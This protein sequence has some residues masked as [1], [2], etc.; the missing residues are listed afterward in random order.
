VT[1]PTASSGG[2]RSE[3][4]LTTCGG[5][6]AIMALFFLIS[7]AACATVSVAPSLP[8]RPSFFPSIPCWL[9]CCCCACALEI[10][11]AAAFDSRRFADQIDRTG[12]TG[13]GRSQ[14]FRWGQFCCLLIDPAAGHSSAPWTGR[15]VEHGESH[16]GTAE[17]HGALLAAPARGGAP[18]RRQQCWQRWQQRGSGGSS[19]PC[20][21]T[22]EAFHAPPRPQQ[23]Q[24][25]PTAGAPSRIARL[26]L[27]QMMNGDGDCGSVSA[28]AADTHDT[29]AAASDGRGAAVA[30]ERWPELD[31]YLD[32]AVP[33]TSIGNAAAKQQQQL[34][35]RGRRG[36]AAAGDGEGGEQ[37]SPS[38]LYESCDARIA[39]ASALTSLE[40]TDTRLRCLPADGELLGG[41]EE[42]QTLR[43]SNNALCE[44]P[45]PIFSAGAGLPRLAVLDL[46]RNELQ[47]LPLSL[48]RLPVLQVLN[49][50][51]CAQSTRV[52]GLEAGSESEQ[53]E[54]TRVGRDCTQ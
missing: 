12:G 45:P 44:L 38:P 50:A 33:R 16:W 40:I 17:E 48:S 1:A 36:N 5:C 8:R 27:S 10:Q 23:P 22:A 47:L 29:V 34:V 42:L 6:G 24:P 18:C 26:P 13:P 19:A 31:A 52:V 11:L 54:L 15:C 9:G 41:L 37:E 25:Q 4:P 35:V 49:A 43:L 53:G 20:I 7:T 32:A 3:M 30:A 46:Q 39:E 21:W 14:S 51:K 2:V 28:A